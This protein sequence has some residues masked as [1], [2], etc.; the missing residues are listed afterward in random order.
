[1]KDIVFEQRN[2]ILTRHIAAKFGHLWAKTLTDEDIDIVMTQAQIAALVATRTQ[3]DGVAYPSEGVL[4]YSTG[5][6]VQFRSI[7]HTSASGRVVW[8]TN[9]GGHTVAFTVYRKLYYQPYGGDEYVDVM[10]PAVTVYFDDGNGFDFHPRFFA[11]ISEGCEARH[12]LHAVN[13]L[14]AIREVRPFAFSERNAYHQEMRDMCEELE[15]VLEKSKDTVPLDMLRRI[16]ALAVAPVGVEDFYAW[17]RTAEDD[18][19]DSVPDTVE[20]TDGVTHYM[21]YSV[22]GLLEQYYSADLT[23]IPDILRRIAA[24]QQAAN[25]TSDLATISSA[26]T[27]AVLVGIDPS[28]LFY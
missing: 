9:I 16:D 12:V 26:I 1:M 19:K 5:G 21:K 14:E 24:A 2:L 3:E 28:R 20:D 13:F 6:T 18:G 22:Q 11:H 10:Y 27:W 25:K 23:Q 17:Y 8:K 4:T 7:E 15:D